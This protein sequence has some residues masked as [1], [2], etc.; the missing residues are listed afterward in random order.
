MGS[1][2]LA[3]ETLQLAISPLEELLYVKHALKKH[4]SCQVQ[5]IEEAILI[6][7]TRFASDRC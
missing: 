4:V 7:W 2:L 5:S 6:I 1:K 3:I